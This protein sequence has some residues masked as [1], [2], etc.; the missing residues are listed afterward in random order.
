MQ[1]KYSIFCMKNVFML[2]FL[3]KSTLVKNFHL[4]SVLPVDPVTYIMTNTNYFLLKSAFI[5]THET[6]N[7]KLP[8]DILGDYANVMI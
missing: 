4:S 3:N 6:R 8:W 1:V 5:A 7:F 2:S